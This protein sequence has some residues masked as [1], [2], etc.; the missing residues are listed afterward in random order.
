MLVL[1]THSAELCNCGPPDVCACV[2][3]N[4]TVWQVKNNTSVVNLFVV[5]TGRL[6]TGG[7]CCTDPVA[8]F[9]CRLISG[10]HYMLKREG[11]YIGIR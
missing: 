4:E 3:Y 1:R 11:A 7:P 10:V 9:S 6:S 8:L 5:A 2:Y